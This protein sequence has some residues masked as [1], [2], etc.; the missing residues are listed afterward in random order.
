[1]PEAN[2]WKSLNVVVRDKQS[3]AVIEYK[4]HL[5]RKSEGWYDEVRYDSHQ[6]MKGRKLPAPHL[7]MKLATPFKDPELGEQELKRII[8]VILPQLKEITE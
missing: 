6:I 3:G 8:D 1:M 7:H 5:F 4:I 2:H